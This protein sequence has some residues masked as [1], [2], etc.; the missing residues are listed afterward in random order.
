[1]IK[2]KSLLLRE[3]C[4][5]AVLTQMVD[6]YRIDIYPESGKFYSTIDHS[7]YGHR[8]FKTPEKAIEYAINKILPIRK[9]V[10]KKHIRPLSGDD[11][12]AKI[13]GDYFKDIKKRGF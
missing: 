1:M 13:T 10:D 7:R 12:Q 8:I 3:E 6:G 11:L 4:P 2:L 9:E 5:P